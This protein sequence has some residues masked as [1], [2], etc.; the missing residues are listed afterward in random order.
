[1]L[2]ITLKLKI[3]EDGNLVPANEVE[4]A[5][6]KQF[7]MSTTSEDVF[8][9]FISKVEKNDKTLGQLAKVHILIKELAS[10]TGHSVEEMKNYIKERAGITFINDE[11]HKEY[12][13]F[14]N[15][16]KSELSLAIQHCIMVGDEIGCHLY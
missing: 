1:M 10:E 4:E 7:K 9:S 13:S 3:N 2:N 15:C 8:D 6:F 11:G 12:K 14:T 16:G 5:K